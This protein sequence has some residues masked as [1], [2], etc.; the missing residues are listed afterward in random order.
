MCIVLLGEEEGEAEDLLECT[1]DIML[2]W[3]EYL[4]VGGTGKEIAQ[5]TAP[6]CRLHG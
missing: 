2:C 3:E 5:E 4:N 1:A 6:I